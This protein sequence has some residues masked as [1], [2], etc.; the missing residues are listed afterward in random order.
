MR[1]PRIL[2]L[3]EATSALDTVT[4]RSIQ[5]ILDGLQGSRTMVVIAHR[6]TTIRNVHEIVVL[7]GGRVVERDSWD[8]IITRGGVFADL[9]RKHRRS[10]NLTGFRR[11]RGPQA[12]PSDPQS[13]AGSPRCGDSRSAT[14]RCRPRPGAPCR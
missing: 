1:D 2:I 7:D 11:E 12:A 4:E 8:V 5:K 6:L 9:V 14:G 3:D 10:R 13:G